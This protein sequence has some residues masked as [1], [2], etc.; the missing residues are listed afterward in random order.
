M[1]IAQKRVVD[2][3]IYI[4][5]SFV[6]VGIIFL[7]YALGVPRDEF[8]R[9]FGLIGA[10]LVIFSF[11][12]SESRTLWS[13]KTFWILISV[14]FFVHCGLFAT[15]EIAKVN[16]TGF[17]IMVICFAEISLLSML[18]ALVFRKH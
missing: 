9:W 5:T 10:T 11:A 13:E 14:V 15:L 17:K 16:L 8:M 18:R 12:I 3:G 2:Y 7:G 1:R 6:V 4:L